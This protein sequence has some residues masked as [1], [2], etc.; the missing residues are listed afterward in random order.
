[1]V[2]ATAA[3]HGM[4]IHPNSISM[5]LHSVPG[6]IEKGNTMLTMAVCVTYQ[7][8]LL[9]YS[10]FIRLEKKALGNNLFLKA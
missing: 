3:V 1:M 7:R 2:S 6:L 8:L 9:T 4:L 10:E 5:H